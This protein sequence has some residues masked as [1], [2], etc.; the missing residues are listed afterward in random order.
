MS[1]L[2]R[3]K[4]TLMENKWGDRSKQVVTKGNIR[5]ALANPIDQ[6]AF[7]PGN[8]FEVYKCT[9]RLTR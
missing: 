1:S 6:D 3:E 7:G 8:M 4:I 2:V 5:H 9:H